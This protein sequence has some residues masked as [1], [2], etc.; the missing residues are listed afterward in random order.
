[1]GRIS[2]WFKSNLSDINASVLIDQI[3][4][5]TNCKI[6][7]KIFLKYK[8]SLS[9]IKGITFPKELPNRNRDYY[10]FPIGVQSKYRNKL[11][12]YLLEKKYLLQ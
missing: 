2:I 4:I 7:K 8:K 3:K 6:K 10:L 1:M 5:M 11:I 12:E 9:A